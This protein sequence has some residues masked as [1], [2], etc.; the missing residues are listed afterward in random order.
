[1][2]S[3]VNGIL[4]FSRS[5]NTLRFARVPFAAANVAIPPH[6]GPLCATASDFI[7][8]GFKVIGSLIIAW[9]A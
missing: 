3:F 2:Y 7:A 9:C 5:R 8:D 4:E 1:V 6:S